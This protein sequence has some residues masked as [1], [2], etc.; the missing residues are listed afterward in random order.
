MLP[1]SQSAIR[2]RHRGRTR[3]GLARAFTLPELA[4][5]LV[6]IIALALL[7]I[8]AMARARAKSSRIKCRN[9]LQNVGLA[10]RIFTTDN[11]GAWPWQ[12]STNDGGSKEFLQDPSLAWPHFHALSNEL[13]TPR[14]ARC[15]NDLTGIQPATW[16]DASNNSAFSYFLGLDASETNPNTIL[17]GDSNLE[18]DGQRLRSTL[19]TIRTNAQ[20]RFDNTRVNKQQGDPWHATPDTGNILHGDG[21]VQQVTSARLREALFVPGDPTNSIHRWLIP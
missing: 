20:I 12:V 18:L 14:I 2:P 3:S 15:P 1:G 9:N 7:V 6:V 4:I 16:R 19:V 10:L 17:G 5:V 8:P 13:S 11:N 21:S